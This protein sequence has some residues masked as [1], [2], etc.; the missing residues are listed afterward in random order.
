MGYKSTLSCSSLD[1]FTRTGSNS[2][3]FPGLHK[4]SQ[5]FA[6]THDSQKPHRECRTGNSLEQIWSWSFIFSDRR[7]WDSNCWAANN[8]GWRRRAEGHGGDQSMEESIW[9][10][11]WPRSSGSIASSAL[12]EDLVKAEEKGKSA[13]VSFVQDR[14]TSSAVRYFETLPR[15]KL[16][17]FGEVERTAA[18]NPNVS[19]CLACLW[20]G[21]STDLNQVIG[22]WCRS[23]GV[24]LS[25]VH[26][27]WHLSSLWQKRSSSCHQCHPGLWA[28]RCRGVSGITRATH[29]HW[30][31][32][33]KLFCWKRE[34]GSF[35][36]FIVMLTVV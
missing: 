27:C 11:R 14:L 17:T 29:T 36:H 8:K 10:G 5:A 19:A 3:C 25:R 31:R 33:K 30:V 16:G 9:D 12:K 23:I 18:T 20:C 21:L 24:L 28:A 22:H 7:A 34:K 1:S 4:D 26:K 32:H 13:L 2:L 15:L 35:V 6:I